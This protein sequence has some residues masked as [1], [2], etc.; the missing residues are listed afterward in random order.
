MKAVVKS[1][2]GEMIDF[3]FG[4]SVNYLT[5]WF[6]EHFS[7]MSGVSCSVYGEDGEQVLELCM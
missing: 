7:G 2:K 1:S 4:T 3:E 6:N 5:D